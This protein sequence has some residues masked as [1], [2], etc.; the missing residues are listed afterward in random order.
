M[1]VCPGPQYFAH[2]LRLYHL[3]V[4]LCS[5]IQNTKTAYASPDYEFA[6]VTSR[7]KSICE[8]KGTCSVSRAVFAP[9]RHSDA[10]RDCQTSRRQCEAP[11]RQQTQVHYACVVHLPL[12]HASQHLRLNWCIG[13]ALLRCGAVPHD[14]LCIDLCD[15]LEELYLMLCRHRIRHRP[16]EA[17]GRPPLQGAAEVTAYC[18]PHNM[19]MH[20]YS[21][22][23]ACMH[24]I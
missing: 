18:L 16:P 21:S 19:T 9:V 12:E 20:M 14:Q 13:K 17:P 23:S 15:M 4:K 10:F 24:S 5:N 8:H 22:N 3:C 7:Q 2:A 6:R 11:A 1:L